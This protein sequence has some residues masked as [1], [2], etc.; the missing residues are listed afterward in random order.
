MA[1]GGDVRLRVYELIRIAL[2]E[3]KSILMKQMKLVLLLAL[4]GGSASAQSRVWRESS[5]RDHYEIV[6]ETSFAGADVQDENGRLT[7]RKLFDIDK[8]PNDLRVGD[9]IT[10]VEDISVARVKEW[11]AAMDRFKPEQKVTIH[12]LRD[13]KPTEV[14]VRLRKISMFGKVV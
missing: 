1:I 2:E 12:V 3:P 5:A 9:V 11:E 4:F 13:G 14:V 7:V 8:F 6:R 10:G